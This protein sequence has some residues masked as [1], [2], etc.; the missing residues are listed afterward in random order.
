MAFTPED[1][2][3]V[4]NANAY[5]DVPAID[6]Y[7]ADRGGQSDWD[8]AVTAAKQAAIVKATDYLDA[9]FGRRW[10][11]RKET[12]AQ[13]LEWP[14]SSAYDA[15][16]YALEGVPAQ[17]VKSLGELAALAVVQDLAPYPPAATSSGAPAAVGVIV[18][19]RERVE[20]AV[21]EETEYAAPTA[22]GSPYAVP[23]YPLAERMLAELLTAKGRVIR[24]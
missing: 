8:A 11:G 20:G 7:W 13:G 21:E 5:A 4:A 3:G 2:T 12:D 16:G 24:A 1:G 23:A 18:R 17:L 14:R 22:V 9:V 15:D 10:K 19:K 6:A